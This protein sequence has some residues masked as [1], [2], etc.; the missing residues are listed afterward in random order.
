MPTKIEINKILTPSNF[1]FYKKLTPGLYS[2]CTVLTPD[3]MNKVLQLTVEHYLTFAGQNHTQYSLHSSIVKNT[4]WIFQFGPY[5][6]IMPKSLNT[7]SNWTM[8][9]QRKWMMKDLLIKL[10][11]RLEKQNISLKQEMIY[12]CMHHIQY[13]RSDKHIIFLNS[14][15]V[16]QHFFTDTQFIS[17]NSLV[18]LLFNKTLN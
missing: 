16:N 3:I 1:D 9:F 12:Q 18:W 4:L 6:W 11:K 2:N 13:L 10:E 17:T 14:Y 7:F 5:I 15:R 8:M